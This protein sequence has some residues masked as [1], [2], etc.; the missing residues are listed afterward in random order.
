MPQGDDRLAA[1]P[2]GTGT[3]IGY[4]PADPPDVQV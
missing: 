3:G 4:I 2:A 1:P